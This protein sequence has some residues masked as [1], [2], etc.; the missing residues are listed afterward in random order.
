MPRIASFLFAAVLLLTW[1]ASASP[2]GQSL[3][4]LA[5]KERERRDENKAQGVAAR[6]FAE[7]E[8]FEQE[9]DF[10]AE[11]GEDGADANESD[12]DNSTDIAGDP[13]GARR[14]SSIGLDAA[15]DDPESA[16]RENESRD[17]S[18][19]EA[20][21]R[22]RYQTAK[23]REAAAQ[24]RKQNLD[25]IYVV[26]G[27]RYVDEKGNTVI[28]SLDHL[29]RLIREAEQERQA[30]AETVKALEEEAHRQNYP[31]GWLR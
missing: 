14:R 28:E 30:A 12:P 29:R 21:F 24:K 8:I 5:R 4:E 16:N 15:L 31:K 6:E 27:V 23:Q 18:R 1:S 2:A 11:E 22:A 13:E 7:A 3:G 10:D 19:R 26:E 17:R 20:D 9:E 25:G